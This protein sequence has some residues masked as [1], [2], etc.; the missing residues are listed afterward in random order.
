MDQLC[1]EDLVFPN[2]TNSNVCV[3]IHARCQSRSNTV[4]LTICDVIYAAELAGLNMLFVSDTGRGKTQL[5]SD[6]T[7]HH[8]G[9][10]GHGGNANWADGRPAFDIAEMFEKTLVDLDSGKFDSDTARQ[11]KTERTRRMLFV[12]DEINRAPLPVQNAFFDIA[13]GKYTHAGQRLSLGRKGYSIFVATANLNRH[14]EDFG[15]TFELDRA[16]LN[17]AHL[18]FDLDHHPFR[19]T[20][21]DELA[22]EAQK[23]DPKVTI[24]EPVDL[25]ARILAVNRQIRD[26]CQKL[27]PYLARFPFSCGPGA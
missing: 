18:T 7:W 22:I 12:I 8:F 2:Y 17:R 14:N 3:R 11:V 9:G 20:P 26:S 25:G 6:M 10:D 21:G 15:G 23:S 1:Y 4:E 13:D 16:L 19:P 27:D 5:I 24:A